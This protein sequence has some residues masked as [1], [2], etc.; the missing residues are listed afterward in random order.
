MPKGLLFLLKDH[1]EL[2][3][4]TDRATLKLNHPARSGAVFI[5]HLAF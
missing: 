5:S 3:G 1:L 4:W 2:V